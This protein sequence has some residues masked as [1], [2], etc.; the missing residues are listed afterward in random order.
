MPEVREEIITGLEREF[1]WGF[2][3]NSSLLF[4]K[5]SPLNSN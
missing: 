3:Q 1:E 5:R 4:K 2:S